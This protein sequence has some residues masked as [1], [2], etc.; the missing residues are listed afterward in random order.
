MPRAVAFHRLCLSITPH[1]G[2]NYYPT[3]EFL[4]AR[5]LLVK[6]IIYEPPGCPGQRRLEHATLPERRDVGANLVHLIIRC[7]RGVNRVLGVVVCGRHVI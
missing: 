5:H 3:G 7:T 1:Y 4:P 6:T 2:V